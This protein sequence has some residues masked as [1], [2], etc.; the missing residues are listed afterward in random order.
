MK[1]IMLRYISKKL[2]WRSLDNG[3]LVHKSL[4]PYWISFSVY[5]IFLTLSSLF[6]YGDYVRTQWAF[7]FSLA[8]FPLLAI[9]ILIG[10][11]VGQKKSLLRH[12]VQ[13]ILHTA[14]AILGL[15][16]IGPI[17]L[18]LSTAITKFPGIGQ[19]FSSI[20][21]LPLVPFLILPVTVPMFSNSI[22]GFLIGFGVFLLGLS[23]IYV[24]RLRQ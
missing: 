12:L 1:P 18:I 8:W 23:A 13:Y 5:A 10:E 2:K 9:T 22:L 3:A 4:V 6:I 19:F 20:I 15:F 11:W 21:Q 17:L 16:V 7:W 24:L 14:S